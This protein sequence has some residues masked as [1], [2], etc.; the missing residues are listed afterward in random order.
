M[1]TSVQVQKRLITSVFFSH[2]QRDSL[3]CLMTV[4]SATGQDPALC[5]MPHTNKSYEKISNQEDTVS[6]EVGP[7]GTLFLNLLWFLR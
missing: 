4:L 1:R 7:I 5:K 6:C 2:W 3:E